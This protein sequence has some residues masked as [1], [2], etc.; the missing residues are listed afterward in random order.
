MVKQ[1]LR[2]ALVIAVLLFL[3]APILTLVVFSFN[4][5]KYMG[6]WTGFSLRWYVE[7]FNDA[8]IM[9]SLWITL[10]VAL[11]AAVVSTILGTLAAAGIHAMKNRHANLV[12]NITY[13][14]ML[15]PDIVTG[16]SLMLLFV[17]AGI[18]LGY[19]TMLLA[20]VTFNLPYV[21]FSVLPKLR[22]LPQHQYEAAIDLGATPGFA[23]RKVVLPQIMP[24]ILTGLI[25]AFTLSIDD[26][27]ISYFTSQDV[28]NL[29]MT[30]YSMARRGLSPKLNALSSIM[31]L[32]V[33]TLLIVINVRS[34]RQGKKETV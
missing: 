14:P 16:I 28:S 3:Y 20:H 2:W 9:R 19:G 22:A 11:I 25:F 10:S 1:A 21:I 15:S 8:V 27:V 32:T 18:K 26:F 23:L 31:F 33:L 5:G 6:N 24:G 29:S 34:A 4:S 30:I 17:F 7:L 13:I 12:E